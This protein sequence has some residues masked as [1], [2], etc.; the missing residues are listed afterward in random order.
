MKQ[1][2]DLLNN[3]GNNYEVSNTGIVRNKSGKCLKC[4]LD[5]RGYHRIRISF[6]GIKNSFRVHRL[7]AEAFIPNP[8]NKLQ[9][10]H[11][12]GDKLNNNASNLEWNT[13]SENQLH[14]IKTG[15]KIIKYGKEAISFKNSIL[16]FDLKGKQIDELFGNLDMKNKGYDFRNVSAVVLGKRKTYKKLIFKRNEV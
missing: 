4:S 7:V 13:N 2:K 3:Y 16:V 6:K 10:N 8:E 15:L 1:W 9:V 5:E 11:I 12:N 14:A